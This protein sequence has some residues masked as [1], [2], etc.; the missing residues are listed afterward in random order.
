MSELAY[1]LGATLAGGILS[2]LAAW[3]LTLAVA[4]ALLP[5]M[6]SY[7]VG[8]LLGATF[9]DLLP[10][11]FAA[12]VAPDI[13]FAVI[14][15][16]LLAFFLLEKAALWRHE[17]DRNARHPAGLMIVA[18][19]GFHN[20]VDGILLAAAFLQDPALGIATAIAVIAHEIPQEAGDFI[21]LLN[22]GYSRRQALRLNLV[23]SLAAVVGGVLGYF[24]LNRMEGAIPYV[25]SLA[26]ASF[27]YIAV[28]DLVPELHRE[29]RGGKALP[30]FALILLGIGTVPLAHLLAG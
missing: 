6:V 17:H 8:V 14:L 26:A 30:Q 5:R 10:E 29:K 25:L 9:L 18:G 28:A 24:M 11:A 21:V 23:S 13:L 16:G 7:A 19:D 20:F 27:I 4:D 1:I 12:P 15:A 22:A 3:L 2:V